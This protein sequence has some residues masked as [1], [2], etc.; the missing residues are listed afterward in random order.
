MARSS[1]SRKPWI[2]RCSAGV[3]L[4]S[5]VLSAGSCRALQ[6]RSR[7]LV[8]LIDILKEKHVIATPFRDIIQEFNRVEE[9]ISGQWVFVPELSTETQEVWA[10]STKFPILGNPQDTQPEGMVLRKNGKTVPFFAGEKKRG[11]GWRWLPAGETLDL[12]LHRG[13]DKEKRGV[14]LDE[15]NVFAIE[16]LLPKGETILDLYVVNPDEGQG[17][18]PVW[19]TFDDSQPEELRVGT[20]KWFRIRHKTSLGKHSIR[21][22]TAPPGKKERSSRRAVLGSVK[23]SCSGDIL[24][25]SRPRRKDLAPPDAAFR[26]SYHTSQP[27]PEEKRPPVPSKI[28]Y[29]Y[30]LRNRFPL[31]DLGTEPNPFSM[32]KK[33]VV[34]EYAMNALVAPPETEFRVDVRV[35]EKAVLEFGFG[36][37]NEFRRRKADQPIRF[38][39]VLESDTER[40]PLLDEPIAWQT[41]TEI[42]TR[43]AD[44]KT[45]AGRRVVLTFRTSFAG[46]PEDVKKSPPVIP[47]W[48]NPVIVRPPETPPLNVILISLDT[49]RADH[50]SCYG[51]RRKTSPGID[52]LAEDGVLFLNTF[53][54]TSW[55]LPGHVS[56]LTSLEGRHHQ[57]YFPLEKMDP[58]T[59]TLADFLR[60][61]GYF[62][63]GFTGGGY[64]SETYGFSKGFDLYQEIKLHGDQAIRFDEAERL[65]LLASDWLEKNREKPFFLFLHTY[66]PHDPY[67]NLSP[68]GKEF[69]HPDAKWDMVRM[70]DLFRGKTRFDMAFSEEEKQ[71][72][73]DLYDGEIKYTDAMLVQPLI[74]K[75]KSL[76]LYDSSMIILTSDHGEEFNDHEA[77]LH[78]HSVYNE[79]LKVPL[80]IKFPNSAHKGQR[81]N[82]VVRITDIVPTIMDFLRIRFP[83]KQVDG[84]S[85][86]PVIRGRETA[87]R[88]FISDLALR[89]FEIAPTLIALNRENFKIIVNKKVVS[90][91]V[92]RVSWDLEGTRIELYDIEKDPGE[93]RNLASQIAYREL[94]LE[95][96]REVETLYA[97]A[98]QERR[99]K[100]EVTL[101]Q[102]LR[103]RLK[104]LGYIR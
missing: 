72:I 56:M 27:V 24:L 37:V 73:V 31:R 104:A 62:C 26:V 19:V 11:T 5:L 88:R 71:N 59:Q 6:P 78:D 53:S 65:A 17:D 48:V 86:L 49:V 23:I 100:E 50:L 34:G 95:L 13:Y 60:S 74:Q 20:K 43:R 89:G 92:K 80:I 41:H 51:Y 91:Y 81:V 69:L 38:Q 8:R 70:E 97:R 67:A 85:L 44:L 39:V 87:S 32:K 4:L 12:R 9:D 57:V 54:T 94:C 102:S 93:T 45:Y 16:R 90:P 47:V 66:Q 46:S 10:V 22:E 14:V 18:I 76:G 30:H 1:A 25:Y 77:W 83:S 64:L 36:I 42:L 7:D 101:D 40:V 2:F 99:R 75:L 98:I 33:I 29:L 55:T 84:R 52:R 63:A 3:S 96:V 82:T 15:G 61:Q 35:P 79:G 28:Q 103:E 68:I 21:I 58:E